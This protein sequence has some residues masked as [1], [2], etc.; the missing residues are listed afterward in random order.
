MSIIFDKI[1]EDN[2][3]LF[4]MNNYDN[5]QC[6]DSEEFYDDLNRFKYIKRLLK[7]YI[8]GDGDDLQERLLLNHITIVYNI[9][10]IEAAQRMMEF[11]FSR[12]YW[13]TL[14]PF[15]IYLNFLPEKSLID[16][17]L[18]PVVVEKLRKI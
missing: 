1:T 4:A 2:F 7:R 18:D 3:V 5:P 8:N 14:K 15:L 16:I 12:D 11:K 17:P 13:P 9:F 10:G 6:V